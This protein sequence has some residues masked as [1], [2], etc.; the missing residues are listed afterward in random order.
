MNRCG[1]SAL[2][3][4]ETHWTGKEHFTTASGELIIFSGSQDHR[5]EAGVILSKSISNS[6]AAYRAISDRILYVRIRA[7]PFNISFIEV[8]AP[9]IEAT[10]EEVEDFHDQIR[11]TIE[12]SQSQDIVFVAG[13]FNAKVGVDCFCPNVY[14][15]HGLGTQNDRGERLLDFCRDHDLF[16]TNTAFKHHERR[17][18]T[19]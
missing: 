19:G 17:R 5:A 18:Y 13:D 4:V 9:T 10:D 15:G 14:G 6:M 11:S 16:V 1:I 3:I 2:G 12:I 8:Y 7:A